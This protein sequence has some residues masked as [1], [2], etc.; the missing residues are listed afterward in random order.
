MHTLWVII[1]FD[2]LCIISSNKILRRHEQMFF[3]ITVQI[4][5]KIIGIQVTNYDV[6]D[7]HFPIPI[8]TIKF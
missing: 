1:A 2:A 7:H 5:N 8:Q 3:T 6:N 4:S